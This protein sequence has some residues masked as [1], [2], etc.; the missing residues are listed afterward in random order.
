MAVSTNRIETWT[1][2][3]KCSL[4]CISML[5]IIVV[6]ISESTVEF[7]LS[8]CPPTLSFTLLGLWGQALLVLG[9]EVQKQPLLVS[10]SHTI[11]WIPSLR[12][13]QMMSGLDSKISSMLWILTRGPHVLTDK[14]TSSST[15]SFS[16]YMVKVLH[17]YACT[18]VATLISQPYLRG[19]AQSVHA[20]H[21]CW[22]LEWANPRKYGRDKRTATLGWCGVTSTMSVTYLSISSSE[23]QHN[24]S[25][26]A[27][28]RQR[29]SRT[30]HGAVPCTMMMLHNGIFGAE[31][32]RSERSLI[33]E[34][35]R[36]PCVL[37]RACH[38][39]F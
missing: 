6:A 1:W 31:S 23:L 12:E 10:N 24:M 2:W 39:Y 38:S 19:T 37:P 36:T 5:D 15:V 3:V 8:P 17:F 30:R 25:S 28:K 7:Y 34:I 27:N 26:M 14:Y 32:L 13:Q 9:V 21:C 18:M 22:S 11:W 33:F 35:S 4:F 16:T 20:L 29:S